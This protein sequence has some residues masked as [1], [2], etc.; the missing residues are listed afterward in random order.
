MASLHHVE[1]CT[2]NAGRLLRL[3]T[4]G[5][6]FRRLGGRVTPRCLQW[7]VR[8][9][10]ATFVLTQ[11]HAQ[12]RPGVVNDSRFTAGEPW[13]QFCYPSG[14]HQRDS[15]FN[16]ALLVRDVAATVSRAARAG[17]H[18]LQ[19]PVHVADADGAAE[20][21]VVRSV[22]GNVVHTLINADRYSGPFLPGFLD[23]NGVSDAAR[24]P[25]EECEVPD[26]S[27]QESEYVD[28]VTL[29]CRRGESTGLLDWY[30]RVFGMRR[31]QLNSQDSPTDGVVMGGEVGMALKAMEY[32]RCA[33]TGLQAPPTDPNQPTLKFVVAESLHDDS[34]VETFNRQHGSPGVQHIGLHTDD[35]V[36]R[37]A[38]MTSRGVNFRR[39][40][41]AYYTQTGKGAEIAAA[42]ITGEELSRFRQLGL[43]LDSEADSDT[44]TGDRYL[45]QIFSEPLFEE[46]TFFMEVLERRGARGFG[47]GNITA[48]A[49]SIIED[50]R[51]RQGSA[52]GEQ[53]K[54]DCGRRAET[55]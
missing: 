23:S 55:G 14:Q 26:I 37:V 17:G 6:G 13:T 7:V 31:F 27:G 32:W 39:P 22:C 28:H 8:S 3:F 5:Y 41:P 51:Q 2:A 47:Q 12:E 40:P 10:R 49:R 54:E 15:V 19:R 29:T 36:S 35:I 33:E 53:G 50:Q 9:G 25:D 42:G 24:T 44:D 43:L 18:V 1:L 52:V 30:Q 11:R 21:A 4:G 46:D 45:M 48:L 34:H 38:G 20:Y 16:V